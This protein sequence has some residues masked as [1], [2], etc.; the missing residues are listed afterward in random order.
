VPDV[1]GAI[2]VQFGWPR[3]R[4]GPQY[5]DVFPVQQF[6]TTPASIEQFFQALLSMASDDAPA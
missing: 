5:P 4:V 2:G 6:P 3:W 1:T